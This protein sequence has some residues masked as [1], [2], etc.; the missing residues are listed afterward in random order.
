MG[1]AKANTTL[2]AHPEMTSE[3]IEALLDERKEKKS[4]AERY[5][6][7][8]DV[9]SLEPDGVPLDSKDEQGMIGEEESV[10]KDLATFDE[11]FK[12]VLVSQGGTD[13]HSGC[14]PLDGHVY[15]HSTIDP[16]WSIRDVTTEV[17]VVVVHAAVAEKQAKG[18]GDL[19]F[20]E[21]K[22]IVLMVICRTCG[23][24]SELSWH[25]GLKLSKA[26]EIPCIIWPLILI[27]EE[28]RE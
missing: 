26:K 17:G 14:V 9:K 16:I 4:Y 2:Q 24:V 27:C 28:K 3:N 21:S 5:D 13:N 11:G 1:A 25:L 18:H 23:V 10:A 8:D 20:K 7:M 22:G 19:G 12:F 15:A 6:D